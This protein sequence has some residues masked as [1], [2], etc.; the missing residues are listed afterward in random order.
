MN[1]NERSIYTA[2]CYCRLSRDDEQDGTSVS[3]ETQ[4]KVLEDYCL[5]NGYSVFDFYCDDGYTG[6]NFERPSF[7]RMMSDVKTGN[8]NMVV[9]KDLSRLG[10]NYIETGRLIEETFPESGVRFIA[11]GDDVD[12]SREN[13]D[14]DLMLPMKNIFNQYYPADC[15]RKTR[16]ALKTKA[17]R[18]EYIGSYAPYGYRKSEEDKHVL[19]IDEQKAPIIIRMFEM[20]AYEGYGY[21]KIARI[22]SEQKVITPSAYQAEISGRR[23]EKD[24][25]DWN[26]ATVHK[27]MENQT[28]LG[29]TING[30]KRKISFKSKRML[31]QPEE[32]WI[33]VENTHP[34]IISE[35]LWDDAHKRLSSRKR[36]NKL[37]DTHIF[38]GLVKCD[39]CGYALSYSNQKNHSEYFCCNTYKKK[40]KDVCSI[41][42]IPYADLYDIVLADI[43]S[44]ISK[45]QRNQETFTKSVLKK[46]GNSSEKNKEHLKN[47]IAAAEK[48]IRELNDRFD[49]LYEDRLDGIISDSKFKELSS[50]CEDEQIKI[51]ARLSELNE[52]A[53]QQIEN[54]NNVSK[55]IQE[56][57]RFSDV[58]ELDKEILNRLIDKIVVSD[59]VKE[60][61]NQMQQVRI[62]YKFLGDLN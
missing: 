18:G 57:N 52:Q 10:R 11:I 41:H 25:Y 29:H 31:K 2:A 48:R 37:G 1:L 17:M 38:A 8:I 7:S 3:I 46:L 20:A 39:K 19:E 44:H 54:E 27:M 43:R 6:T 60:N 22:L 61:G 35:Q 59:R 21:N 62:I 26:L 53:G 4:K 9:V 32:K 15:S 34:P 5:S 33:V 36:V 23:F 16:Q 40:G 42:Y 58:N 55:F 56:I 45:A 28:Y 49:K 13:L 50:R 24:P 30:R 14:L 51:K 12:T 47:E